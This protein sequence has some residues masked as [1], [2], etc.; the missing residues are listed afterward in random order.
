MKRRTRKRKKALATR[1]A[2]YSLTAGAALAGGQAAQGE[3][4]WSG[5]KDILVN[6]GDPLVEIDLDRDLVPDFAVGIVAQYSGPA[7]WATAVAATSLYFGQIQTDNT[8]VCSAVRFTASDTVAAT[9]GSW[10]GGAYL[11]FRGSHP[12]YGGYFQG[13]HFLGQSGYAGVK[14]LGGSGDCVGWIA[15]EAAADAT[16]ARITGWACETDLGTIH[17]PDVPEPT[18]L[19]LLALGAAGLAAYR[20]RRDS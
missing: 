17:V 15:I 5:E 3:I 8:M 16:W 19:A 20:K 18:G 6:V 10:A 4:I 11:A 9:L 7:S 1:L 14:F 12:Y 13:G 2:G